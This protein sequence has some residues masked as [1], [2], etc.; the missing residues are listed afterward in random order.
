M[1][2]A[3]DGG[4]GDGPVGD[5]SEAVESTVAEAVSAFEDGRPVLV[6]D[7]ADREDEIDILQPARAVDP[8]AVARLR[9]D[10][11]GMICVALSD[12]VAE[13]LGLPF[14]HEA[15]DHPAA[16]VAD[17]AY[18]DRPAFS[19]PVNHRGVRTGVT[20]ADRA[21]TITALAEVAA[22]PDEARFAETFRVPGH[23]SV[24]R[25]A[26]DGLADRQGHTELGLALAAAADRAPAVVVCE[27]LEDGAGA[28]DRAAARRYADHND[29]PFLEGSTLIEAFR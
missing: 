29:L 10:A 19:L 26:P 24:L 7:A 18:D 21:R 3:P 22:S 4:T 17:L 5:R 8:D 12:G 11:G 14:L 9:S 28:R 13:T 15:V 23:V 20:D 27:M 1:S 2:P 25:G 6:H 16:A